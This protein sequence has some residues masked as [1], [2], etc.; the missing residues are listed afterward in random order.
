MKDGSWQKERSMTAFQF[1]RIVRE[2]GM[3]QAGAGR[4]IGV[5]LR[6]LRRIVKGQAEVPTA[7]ALL[8]RSLVA[9]KEKPLVPK[10]ERE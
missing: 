6:T 1:R 8:L 3:S 9:H 2:L 7:A 10:W 4:Y 5:S